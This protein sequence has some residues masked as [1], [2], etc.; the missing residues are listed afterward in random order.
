MTNFIANKQFFK[1]GVPKI[2]TFFSDMQNF[3]HIMPEQV[4]DWSANSASCSFFIKNLGK[5]NMKK[6]DVII[7]ERFEFP[8]GENSKVN[9]TLAFCLKSN[10]GSMAEGYFELLADMNPMVEMM[11]RRPLTNFVNILTENLQQ[12]MKDG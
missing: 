7:P 3:K 2:A 6:G 11:A 4:E 10:A 8:S 12:V 1:C 9:F 5:L